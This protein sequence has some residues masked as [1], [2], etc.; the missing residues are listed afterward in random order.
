[1]RE[2]WGSYHRVSFSLCRPEVRFKGEKGGFPSQTG[3][4]QGLKALTDT[5]RGALI[6]ARASR[7]HLV[8]PAAARA[9]STRYEALAPV[10]ASRLLPRWAPR[11][12]KSAPAVEGWGAK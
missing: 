11:L 7:A 12:T 4:I 5:F 9:P 1:M 2:W 6:A 10:G 3:F 8:A